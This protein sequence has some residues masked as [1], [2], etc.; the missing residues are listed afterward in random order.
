[1]L[2]TE[3]R[4]N[5]RSTDPQ[6]DSRQSND[7]QVA[8]TLL[9]RALR[10]ARW[11]ILW[12]RL[13]PA[14]A[15]LGVAIGIFLSASWAG[16]WL[17]LPPMGRAIALFV[18]IVLIAVAA[19][20]LFRFRLP[21]TFDGLRRLDRGSG[22]AHRPATTLADEIATGEQD[23][24]SLALW[25]AHVEQ[26]LRAADA[27]KA[28]TPRPRLHLFDPIAVRALVVLLVAA[29]FFAASG[30]RVRRITAAFD[31]AG[32]VQAKNFRVDAWVTPPTYTGKPPL[33]LPG[34][35]AGEP[36]QA[37]VVQTVPTGSVLVIRASGASGLEV[38]TSGG[39]AAA[40]REGAPTPPAG[41][42][43]H[44]YT[45]TERGSATLRGAL[46]E[47]V[48]FTFAAIP[49]RPPTIALTK[50]PEPQARG[51]LQLSYKMEDDYGVV[52]ALATFALKQKSAADGRELRSL[53]TAPDFSLTLP[54]ARTRNGAGQTTK[55]LSDHPWAGAEVVLTL[56]A[57]DEAGNEG[58]SAPAEFKLPERV[59]VKPLARALIEQRRNLALD[60]EAA[61]KVLMALDALSIAPER[62]MPEA[63]HYLGLR[64]IRLNLDI[65]LKF[66]EANKATNIDDRLREVVARL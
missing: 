2:A 65:A 52:G 34:I 14:L 41:T 31:W 36:H 54:Q 45:I 53:Y 3:K 24:V 7:E 13:W 63:S 35:R 26:A 9:V 60:A 27:L 43:E 50:D 58:S 59:F 30:E 51:A 28:G 56:T 19:V 11:T 18:L 20:P 47:D 55:D 37:A 32:V 17:V 29:T 39:L 33:I 5:D 64:A 66:L 4:V 25:R 42:E 49:D 1:M 38:V 15:S 16:L 57:R 48:T 23:Q 8:D 6:A 44:R 10:R 62:F 61:P 40:S 12:E 46:D 21:S 22:L